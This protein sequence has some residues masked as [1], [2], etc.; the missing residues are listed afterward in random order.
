M[1]FSA[2]H[3]L[4]SSALKGFDD[5]ARYQNATTLLVGAASIVSFSSA[6]ASGPTGATINGHGLPAPEA[7]CNCA[8]FAADNFAY[9]QNTAKT[10]VG[11]STFSYDPFSERWESRALRY[12][13]A[14]SPGAD[15]NRTRTNFLE[16][17][18]LPDGPGGAMF[19]EVA[20]TDD[21]TEADSSVRSAELVRG[22]TSPIDCAAA[23]LCDRQCGGVE[24]YAAWRAG[25]GPGGGSHGSS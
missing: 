6:S 2:A 18:V 8:C 15:A 5:M 17:A 10:T 1:S 11:I 14:G 9:C 12:F 22:A 23:S 3:S 16:R 19:F 21:S 7:L 24:Q 4:R 13:A 20:Y 25:C